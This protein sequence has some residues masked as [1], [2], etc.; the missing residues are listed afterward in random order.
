[1]SEPGFNADLS[2]L[3]IVRTATTAWQASHSPTV[4]RK[5]L[6]LVGS[7]ESSRVTA[8]AVCVAGP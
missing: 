1:M 5:R 2:K 4:W 7:A 3:A 6:D 8:V